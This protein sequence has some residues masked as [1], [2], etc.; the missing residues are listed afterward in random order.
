[1]RRP[2]RFA[3]HASSTLK[4][5]RMLTSKAER[6]KSLQCSSQSAARWKTQSTPF[7]AVSSKSVCR[8]FPPSSKIFTRGSRRS[9]SLP[10]VE[11][12]DALH[13]V[14]LLLRRQLG[15]HRQ[16]HGLAR[17]PLGFGE[18]PRLV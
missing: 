2:T 11:R 16:R 14:R 4:V 12:G 18:V 8:M 10:P 1:M 3:T 7:I 9:V 15:V 5:P 17:G 13:H 6:G